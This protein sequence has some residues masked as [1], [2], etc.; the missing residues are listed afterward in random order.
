MQ[1]HGAKTDIPNKKNKILVNYLFIYFINLL[2]FLIK[3]K[4]YKKFK[5][6]NL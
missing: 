3:R 4:F 2:I 6:I 1:V 5:F